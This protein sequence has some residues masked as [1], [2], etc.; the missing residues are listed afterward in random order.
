MPIDTATLLNR[1]KDFFREYIVESHTKALESASHLKDYHVNPFLSTYLANF[2]EGNSNPSSIAKAL[3]YPRILGTSVTTSFGMRA[4]QMIHQIF[5]GYG[6]HG[7]G[8]DLEFIDAI[9]GTKKYCQLKAGPNTINRDDITT[10]LNHFRGIRNLAR[11]N[12]LN[13]GINDLV[14]GVLYGTPQELSIHYRKISEIH[15]V[16]IGQGFWHRLT[17]QEDFYYQLIA[18][19]GEVALEGDGRERLDAAINTLALEIEES[20]D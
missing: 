15:P 18:A 10:I 17:G 1:A 12:N 9:D 4:Q 11:T 2:L 3:L 7:T 20:M 8:L 13:I 6:S 5:E 16:Y 14:V 19:I